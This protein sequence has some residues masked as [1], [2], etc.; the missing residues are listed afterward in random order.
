MFA[1]VET[2]PDDNGIAFV[3]HFAPEAEVVELVDTTD[4]KFVAF[5][6]LRVRV[7]PSVPVKLLSNVKSITFAFKSDISITQIVSTNTRKVY[8]ASGQ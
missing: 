2:K 5:A 3:Y 8:Y 7:P 6:G 4:S 1:K